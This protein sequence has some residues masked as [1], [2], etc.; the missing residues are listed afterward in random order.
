MADITRRKL[1]QTA[2]GATTGLAAA[3]CLEPSENEEPTE[4][5]TTDDTTATD[6]YDDTNNETEPEPDPE[7]EDSYLVEDLNPEEKEALEEAYQ[8]YYGEVFHPEEYT[9]INQLESADL[10]DVYLQNGTMYV[11]WNSE[12]LIS[13]QDEDGEISLEIATVV[14]AY[15]NM[16]EETEIAVGLG[17]EIADRDDEEYNESIDE[18]LAKEYLET[19]TEDTRDDMRFGSKAGNKLTSSL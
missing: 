6:D 15:D 17:V 18:S 13:K 7:E 4:N 9:A 14:N 12:N 19:T 8:D 16:V 10:N 5:T 2:A 1:L 3:G 11:N